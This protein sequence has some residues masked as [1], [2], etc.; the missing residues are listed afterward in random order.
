MVRVVS[1]QKEGKER[2]KE[3]KQKEENFMGITL[4]KIYLQFKSLPYQFYLQFKVVHNC[5]KIDFFD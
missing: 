1:L 2:K 3:R 4:H 5:D